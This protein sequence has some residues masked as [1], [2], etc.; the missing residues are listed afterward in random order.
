LQTSVLSL[1]GLR[2]LSFPGEDG[3]IDSARDQAGRAVLAAL[4][5]YGLIAQ[6][7]SG[8]L[9][10]SRCELLPQDAGRLELIGRTLQEVEA[11]QLSAEGARELLQQALAHAKRHGLAFRDHTLVLQADSRLQELVRR[12][13]QAAASGEP[14]EEA[15]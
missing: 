4:A 5:L 10:R 6:N 8:Y 14:V 12:S 15:K 1:S 9:L 2:H 11:T 3:A 13:R 7:E